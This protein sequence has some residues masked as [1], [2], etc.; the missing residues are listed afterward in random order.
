MVET[1]VFVISAIV[2]L[3]GAL[4]VVLRKHPVHAALSMVQ[5]LFGVAVLF[6]AME[7]NFLAAVQVIVYA[8]AIVVLFLFVIMLVG[9]DKVEKIET[10][11]LT[12]QKP[13]AVLAGV[14]IFA[15]MSVTFLNKDKNDPPVTGR[16][17]ATAALVTAN[18]LETTEQQ[19]A[20]AQLAS[21]VKA[22]QKQLDQLAPATASAADIEAATAQLELARAAVTNAANADSVARAELVDAV[23]AAQRRVDQLRSSGA[24]SADIAVPQAQL[25][26]ARETVTNFDKAKQAAELNA[27]DGNTKLLAKNLF[28]EYNFAFQATGVLLVIA[29]I[30][31]VILARRPTAADHVN[32][33]DTTGLETLR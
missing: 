31:A 20:N 28:N 21:D 5:T 27:S 11:P 7:A 32:A 26:V 18:S 12:A 14:A 4:G 9:L 25:D 1:V 16:Q 2:I 19:A 6:V 13:L 23:K 17:S 3:T 22:A 8:G 33:V 29:V 10:S 30:G 24:S 15:L